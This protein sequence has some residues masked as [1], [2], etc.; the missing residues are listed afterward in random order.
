MSKVSVEDLSM[1]IYKMFVEVVV[2]PDHEVLDAL[3]YRQSVRCYK[4]MGPSNA[5]QNTFCGR[6]FVVS[7]VETT[8]CKFV[9]SSSRLFDSDR[10]AQTRALA[11]TC[12]LQLAIFISQTTL[13]INWPG[14]Y[15]AQPR[16]R[17]NGLTFRV[18][19]TDA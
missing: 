7:E 11:G 1:K 3:I 10:C 15:F 17:S 12:L 4:I 13:L 8:D 2:V 18:V 5:R 14:P 16:V 9:D 19:K 6:P